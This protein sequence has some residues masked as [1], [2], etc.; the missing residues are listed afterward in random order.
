MPQR[1]LYTGLR[2][3]LVV[4]IDIGTTFSGVSYALLEP[5]QLPVI[6]GVSQWVYH[7]LPE[8]ELH[9][10]YGLPYYAGF[11]G[12]K[13]LGATRKFLASFVTMQRGSSLGWA[14]RQIQK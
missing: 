5:R 9:V 14:Q 4:A 6:R 8:S 1:K 2:P 10:N 11:Q 7:H 3:K 12:N 13:R